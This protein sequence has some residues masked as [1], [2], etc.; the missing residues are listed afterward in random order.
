MIFS[1]AEYVKSQNEHQVTGQVTGT[2]TTYFQDDALLEWW[3]ESIAEVDAFCREVP[4]TETAIGRF[5][6][7]D[8]VVAA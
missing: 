8:R 4:H 3:R 1:F 7:A 2:V 5:L 6:P